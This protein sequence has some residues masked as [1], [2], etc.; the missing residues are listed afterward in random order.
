MHRLKEASFGAVAQGSH[1]RCRVRGRTSEAIWA[2]WTTRTAP[3]TR[4]PE[5]AA[6]PRES[7]LGPHEPEE[8]AAARLQPPHNGA[9]HSR[10]ALLPRRYR[11]APAHPL[12]HRQAGPTSGPQSPYRALL[13]CRVEP[14]GAGECRSLRRV[15]A[16]LAGATRPRLP[17]VTAP[18][19]GS[20][21]RRPRQL[22][23]RLHAPPPKPLRPHGTAAV[24]RSWRATPARAEEEG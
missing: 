11:T 14:G 17:P 13:R 12:R 4:T 8:D 22:A 24:C 21:G 3:S 23:P 16:D 9:A 5:P 10:A 6:G 15:R 2:S 1:T 7:E 18:Q 19:P 20:P